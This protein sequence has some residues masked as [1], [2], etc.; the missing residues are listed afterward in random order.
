MVSDRVILLKGG[1]IIG[2]G[3]PKTTITP[4]TLQTLYQIDVDIVSSQGTQ[5][6]I[7]SWANTQIKTQANPLPNLQGGRPETPA[8]PVSLAQ[9]AA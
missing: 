9:K 3:S 7:P 6:C 4:Q 8:S 2:D 1:T 5:M